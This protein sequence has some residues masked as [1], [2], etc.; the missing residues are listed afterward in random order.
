MNSAGFSKISTKANCMFAVLGSPYLLRSPRSH[1]YMQ[2]KSYIISTNSTGFSKLFK[3]ANCM[4]AV[5]GSPY[6]VAP[7]VLRA[8][9]PQ[10]HRPGLGMRSKEPCILTKEPYI[11]LC[12]P[13]KR[14]LYS[15]MQPPKSCARQPQPH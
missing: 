5:L 15:T 7:E 11:L 8:R 4:F 2:K 12:S 3:G 14:A 9:P 13:N 1:K 10:P 6:Y